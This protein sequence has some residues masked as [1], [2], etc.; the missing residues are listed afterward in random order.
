M[1]CSAPS[2]VFSPAVPID[3][4]VR[5]EAAPAA[6][7]ADVP[8]LV[9]AQYYHA[10]EK[11]AGGRCSAN[12]WQPFP[13]WARGEECSADKMKEWADGVVL[14]RQAGAGPWGCRVGSSVFSGEK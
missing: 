9:M 5:L 12:L 6:A 14:G 1:F 13:L 3:V 11:P 4:G 8:L 10:A 2:Q 7:A